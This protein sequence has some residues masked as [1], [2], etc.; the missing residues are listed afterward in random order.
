MI[1]LNFGNKVAGLLISAQEIKHYALTNNKLLIAG[2]SCKQK[3][4]EAYWTA[5]ANLIVNIS[6]LIQEIESLPE[7]RISSRIEILQNNFFASAYLAPFVER[8]LISPKMLVIFSTI[9]KEFDQ[10]MFKSIFGKI[11]RLLNYEKLHVIHQ[12]ALETLLEWAEMSILNLSG[13][14][15]NCDSF[16]DDIF[17]M[18]DYSKS[19]ISKIGRVAGDGCVA[20]SCCILREEKT[21][22]GDTKIACD[23]NTASTCSMINYVKDHGE[24]LITYISDE[25][26]RDREGRAVIINNLISFFSRYHRNPKNITIIDDYRYMDNVYVWDDVDVGF[27]NSI[28]STFRQVVLRNYHNVDFNGYDRTDVNISIAKTGVK[29]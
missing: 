19:V 29:V 25:Y 24:E 7:Q 10:M 14:R 4:L 12:I 3:L 8:D 16:T 15:F 9:Q 13:I 1:H 27:F 6:A 28:T 23:L 2:C 17:E 5:I 11:N 22:N 20:D 18:D 26:M 21:Q